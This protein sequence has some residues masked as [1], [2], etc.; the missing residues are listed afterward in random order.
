MFTAITVLLKGKSKRLDPK[1]GQTWLIENI[2][3][4]LQMLGTKV[5]L[6]L[7]LSM[8]TFRDFLF[9]FLA[10]ELTAITHG[11]FSLF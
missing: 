9:L 6:F 8:K 11:S 10:L 4:M 2:T 3:R 7:L 1:T 5:E